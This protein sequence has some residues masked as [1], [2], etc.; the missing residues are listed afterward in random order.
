MRLTIVSAF[1]LSVMSVW[2][3]R[4]AKADDTAPACDFT[5]EQAIAAGREAAKADNVRFINFSSDAARKIID[6]INAMPPQSVTYEA[7][8]FMIVV[9]DDGDF[10]AAAFVHN[11][12]VT[13][14]I[15]IPISAWRNLQNLVFGAGA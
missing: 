6:A 8:R 2:G 7:E 9:H 14:A 1:L 12:C 4:S 15:H 3:V 10:V 11:G 5:Y 13:K